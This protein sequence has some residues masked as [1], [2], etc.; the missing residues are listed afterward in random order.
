MKA[1]NTSGFGAGPTIFIVDD[2]ESL[3]RGLARLMRSH[4]WDVEDFESAREFLERPAYT[5][6]GCAVLDVRMPDMTGPELQAQ[7]LARGDP[8]PLVFLSACNDVATAV[9]A[10][11]MGG[12]DFLTKPVDERVLLHAI[13]DGLS[14]HSAGL[15]SRRQREEVET[16]LSR[17]S[18]REREVMHLVAGGLLN[19]LIADQLGISIGTVKVHRGRVMEKMEVRSVAELVHLCSLADAGP[20]QRGRSA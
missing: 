7:L 4:G 20:G 13:H 16:R 3:R 18:P 8:L 17:L 1:G 19:K 11:K 6:I 2:D 9:H 5:G 12:A 14:R 15:T 10:M